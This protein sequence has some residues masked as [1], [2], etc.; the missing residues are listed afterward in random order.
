ML[1]RSEVTP[2]DWPLKT[3]RPPEYTPAAFLS[4]EDYDLS[5][6]SARDFG[7]FSIDTSSV[8]S[9]VNYLSHGRNV[10]VNIHSITCGQVTNNT[11]G[12]NFHRRAGQLR[13][14]PGLDVIN[15]L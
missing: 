3:N 10:R 11:L 6:S 2:K 13:K 9:V 14:A 8:E 15:S 12:G 5:L 4:L 7:G 1:A